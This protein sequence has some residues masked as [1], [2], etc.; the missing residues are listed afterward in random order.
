[1]AAFEVPLIHPSDKRNFISLLSSEAAA[2]GYHVDAA[3]DEELSQL[4]DVSP[5]TFNATVW[6]G[7]DEESIATA[8]DGADNL[9]R[10]WIAFAKSEQP[11]KATLFRNALVEQMK[12][13]W[14]DTISIPVQPSGALPLPRDRVRTSI[15]YQVKPEESAKYRHPDHNERMWGR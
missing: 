12:R 7:E 14:P 8:M 3:T 4:S 13:R 5:I 1:M 10:V 2:H 15:G 11:E 6:R 9:G